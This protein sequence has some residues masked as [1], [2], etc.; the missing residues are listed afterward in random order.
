VH[1]D[2]LYQD[3]FDDEDRAAKANRAAAR[4]G[5]SN[6]ESV[7]GG[8]EDDADRII[9]AQDGVEYSLVDID[10]D[11]VVARSNREI[12]DDNARQTLTPQEIEELKREGTG[13]GK[14]LIAKLMLSHT[15]L[16]QKTTFSLAKYKL[17]KTKKYI[18]R[19]SVLPYDVALMGAWLLEEKDAGQKIMELRE[20]MI[21]LLGCWANVRYG[22][23]DQFHDEPSTAADGI[24]NVLSEAT[25]TGVGRW[26][27]VD[28][29]GGLLVATMAERM[30]LLYAEP[31][32]WFEEDYDPKDGKVTTNGATRKTEAASVTR[33]SL[34]TNGDEQLPSNQDIEMGLDSIPRLPKPP[35]RK[36]VPRKDDFHIPYSQTNTITLIHTNPQ[37]NLS[38]LDRHGFDSTS[39]NPMPHP[40]N[41]HLLSLTWLQLVE[42]ASDLTY[43]S[44]PVSFPTDIVAS[45]KAN[46]R[47]NYHRKRRRWARTKYTV[48][49]TRAGGFSG[50]LVATSM[51]LISVFRHTLPLLAGGA[52][53]AVYSPQ[54]EPLAELAD[55]FSIPRRGAWVSSIGAEMSPE[56][57]ERWPGSDE[58]P[59]NPA[60][61]LGVMVQTSRARKWQV[62]PGRTHPVM[63]ARGGAEGYIFTAWRSYPAEGKVEARGKYRRRKTGPAS[64]V[65][66]DAATPE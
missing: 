19:F 33:E 23:E 18:R 25:G 62:L 45:W 6:P 43:N 42:P 10:S 52:P 30:G 7:E 20:E 48:D 44:D 1:P 39:A 51:D 54:L 49:R 13:A 4:E 47:G 28:D 11:A 5:H 61:L 37:P 29:T 35:R 3:I 57:Q 60:L 58:F 16:D 8:D 65:V 59:L 14:D 12:I 55:C 36:T 9:S 56:E 66:R 41:E 21:A 17:T 27:V 38:Y 46:R 32:D 26:L 34:N 24:A 63:T 15:A 53:V 64:A 22:G 50:L 40:L 2:E 31:E